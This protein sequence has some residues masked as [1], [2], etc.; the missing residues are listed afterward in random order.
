MNPIYLGRKST[1]VLKI[2]LIAVIALVLISSGFLCVEQVDAQDTIR[3]GISRSPLSA[4]LIIAFDQGYFKKEGVEVTMTEYNSGK[5]ALEGLLVGEVD[6]STV[7]GT[8]IMF[9]SF[10]R[11]DFCILGT[12]VYSYHDTKMIARK[13]KGIEQAADLKGKRIGVNKGTTAQFFLSAFLV[14]SG[15][16]TSEVELIDIS[17]KN[18]PEALKNDSV[19]AIAVWEP[20]A[21]KAM[22]LLKDRA[23]RL[24]SSKI[25]RT[26]FNVVAMKDFIKSHPTVLRK[27]LK[28]VDKASLFIKKQ[29][30]ISKTIVAKRLGKKKQALDAIW[31]E[32]TYQL[33]L[34]QALI[35]TLADE[36]RWAIRNNLTNKTKVPNFMKFICLDALEAVNHRAVTIIR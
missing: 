35:L 20:H 9:N 29:K 1:P 5:L 6:V 16:L 13:D 17:S 33:F 26:T 28:V 3:L 31:D 19:D 21:Y 34:D 25:Y 24:P 14:Y 32:Y 27:V 23:I 10:K 18:L 15:L 12:F 22:Q 2:S 7:A 8:P 4:P 36:A 30:E 11:Q